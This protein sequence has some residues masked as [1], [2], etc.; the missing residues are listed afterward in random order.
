M[1]VFSLF[2]FLALLSPL[3][4]ASP[5]PEVEITMSVLQ[6]SQESYEAFLKEQGKT[7]FEVSSLKSK[8]ANRNIVAMVTLMQAL[9]LGG[10]SP[11]LVLL[12][13]PN[14]AREI[15]MVKSGTALLVHQDAW[16]IDFDDSVYKSIDFIP[17]GRF[18]KGL[19]VKASDKDKIKISTIADFKNYSAVSNPDWIVDWNTLR[20]LGL[21]KLH[22]TQDK[23]HMINVVL[24]RDV[25][26]TAQE[27]SQAQ[28]MAYET[29]HGR[30][31]PLDGIKLAL[32]STRSFMVSKKHKDGERVF[33]AL[34]KGLAILQ[35]NGTIERY[36]TE[37]GFYEVATKNWKT[38]DV[39]K[40][41]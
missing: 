25:D 8:Y 29:P 16:D 37:A 35:K 32:S 13:A 17:H 41:Q 27:F 40:A 28:D 3:C 36:L 5:A 2:L 15:Q 10:I 22:S 24:V 34:Q 31:V 7:V 9:K 21:K 14:Y 18:V 33:A 19:Y 38:L 23:I 30:L 11:K 20:R 12:T 4:A 26:F 39:D 6:R 1:P